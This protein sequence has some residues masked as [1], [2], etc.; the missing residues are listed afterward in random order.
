MSWS[1]SA[2][3]HADTPEADKDLAARV[4]QL[5]ADA[6]PA[7]TGASWAGSGYSGDPR[8]L[9]GRP[10]RDPEGEAGE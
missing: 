6:G 10:G 4:G 3:G 8:E 2:S 7:V 9:A 1:L 5:L